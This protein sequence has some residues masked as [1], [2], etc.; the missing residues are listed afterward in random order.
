MNFRFTKHS[1]EKFVNTR[2][3]G[4]R[5]TKKQIKNTILNPFKTEIR[6][7]NTR[8]AMTIV[9]EKHVLRVVYRS[10]NDIIVII[11]FYPGRKKAYEI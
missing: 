10:E 8:I 2:K 1:L 5:F 6:N 11:T 3:A 7:D 9:D 4:F